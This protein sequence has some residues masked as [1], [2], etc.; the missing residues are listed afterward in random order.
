M[1][2]KIDNW[3]DKLKEPYRF[4]VAMF[5]LH[6]IILFTTFPFYSAIVALMFSPWY[7]YRFWSL[8]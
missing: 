8:K 2:K 1:L 7:V 5:A 4:S 3:Y 6:P